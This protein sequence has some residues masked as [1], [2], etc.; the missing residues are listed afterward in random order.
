MSSFLVGR[1]PIRTKL[2]KLAHCLTSYNFH[3]LHYYLYQALSS[4]QPGIYTHGILYTMCSRPEPWQGKTR[5]DK[6]FIRQKHIRIT[7]VS[8]T[9]L[10]SNKTQIHTKT[11]N[12]DTKILNML[13]NWQLKL[14]T[15]KLKMYIILFDGTQC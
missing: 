5:Q 11:K 4:T 8:V 3:D 9:T 10:S 2:A 1:M 13:H 12:K 15:L 14:Y 6:H 7:F